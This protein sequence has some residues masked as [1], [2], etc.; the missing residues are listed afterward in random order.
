MKIAYCS[1]LHIEHKNIELPIVDAD[2]LVLA[3]DIVPL[4]LIEYS[5]YPGP[6]FHIKVFFENITAYKHVIWIMGNHEYYG[7]NISLINKVKKDLSV[8]KNLHILVDETITL[9]G[10]KFAGG[11]KW[12]DMNKYDPMTINNA[13]NYMSDFRL[14]K[15]GPK[16][17]LF[18]ASDWLDLHNDFI[19]FIRK[20]KNS[21]V[22]ITHHSPSSQTTLNKFKHEFRG[23]GYYCDSLEEFIL[24]SNFKLW[25][26]GHQHGAYDIEIGEC[27]IRSNPRG[28]P[29]EETFENF[30]MKIIEI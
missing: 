9:D 16:D 18:T 15:V 13:K 25:L 28:Y 30:Q 4:N 20:H 17:T 23:N 6:F 27:K 26:F 24:D 12:T 22:V 8:Y 1:D 7:C 10:I 11:T 29:G 2:V 3:G 21:D 14:I 19:Y 5:N